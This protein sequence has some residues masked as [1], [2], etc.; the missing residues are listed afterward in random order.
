M[1]SDPRDIC[2]DCSALPARS[3][4]TPEQAG[5]V[6]GLSRWT[7]YRACAAGELPAYRPTGPSGRLLIHQDEL[8]AWV[9]RGRVTARPSRASSATARTNGRSAQRIP[10]A[11]ARL[12]DLTTDHNQG[13]TYG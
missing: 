10:S 12:N 8:S 9:E 1:T 13:G 3:F 7:I 6:I 2:S 5:R 11:R 4:L